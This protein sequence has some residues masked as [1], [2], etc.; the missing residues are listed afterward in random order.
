[1]GLQGD[2]TVYPESVVT[3]MRAN[4]SLNVLNEL[5]NMR[6]VRLNV[7]LAY[8]TVD[9]SI[10]TLKGPITTAA[11]DKL[12]NIFPTFQKKEGFISRENRLPAADSHGISCFIDIFEKAAKFEIDV[13]CKLKV[14]LYGLIHGVN[15]SI[16]RLCMCGRL[17]IFCP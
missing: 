17:V 1:M 11:D 16:I 14:A 4:V 6:K 9:L 12:R 15:K 2:I 10:L 3:Y 5:I 13:F 7:R 8:V